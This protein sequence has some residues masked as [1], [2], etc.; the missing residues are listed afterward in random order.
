LSNLIFITGGARSGKSN[1]AVQLANKLGGSVV[2]IATARAEDEEMA[3]RILIHKGSRPKGWVTIE[4]PKDIALAVATA[5]GY[6]V[7][8]IDC[9]ILF[10]SN[11][12]REGDDLDDPGEI[13]RILNEIKKVTEATR[14]FDGTVIVVSNEI[15]MG[16]VPENKL[17][18]NFRDLAGR[19]NQ[20]VAGA[21]NEV[22][23]CFSGIPLRIK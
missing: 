18:R 16:I 17:A 23:L 11:L 4:E 13:D 12:I 7:I 6:D 19:T 2:F 22:Y 20:M 3:G 9:L 1:L 15:G 10:L 14:K 21:A 5:Y 8:I